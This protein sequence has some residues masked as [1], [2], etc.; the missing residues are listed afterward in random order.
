M[1]I[2]IINGHNYTRYIRRQGYGWSREDVDG[3]QSVRT[4]SGALRRQKICEKR[5]LRFDLTNM[6]RTTLAALDTDLGAPAFTVTYLDLHGPQTRTFCCTAFSAVL[7]DV[8]GQ[9]GEVWHD[10]GFQLIEV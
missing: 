6:N 2:L 7:S 3:A 9:S 4:R 8:Q 10:A 5:R 1:E